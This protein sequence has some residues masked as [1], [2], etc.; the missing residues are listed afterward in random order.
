M[1]KQGKGM[2]Q[3]HGWHA[4]PCNATSR[5]PLTDDEVALAAVVWADTGAAPLGRETGR[6]GEGEGEGER[7]GEKGGI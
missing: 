6:E 1:Q 3:S 2:L 5:G 4:R 7:E